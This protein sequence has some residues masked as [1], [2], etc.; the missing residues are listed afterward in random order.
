MKNK[1]REKELKFKLECAEIDFEDIRK[2]YRKDKERLE[3]EINK[4]RAEIFI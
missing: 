4:L 3:K 1:Q 2:K